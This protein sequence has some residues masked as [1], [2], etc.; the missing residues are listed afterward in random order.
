MS[1]SQRKAPV[2]GWPL[3]GKIK[4]LYETSGGPGGWQRAV[5]YGQRLANARQADTL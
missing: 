4:V 2:G 1:V 5:D 3:P